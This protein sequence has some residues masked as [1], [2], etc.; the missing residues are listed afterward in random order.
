[1]G[2]PPYYSLSGFNGLELPI[3]KPDKDEF[4]YTIMFWFR[5]HL[6]IQD[7]IHDSYNKHYLFEMEGSVSCF[8]SEGTKL[9]C[10]TTAVDEN[11]APQPYEIQLA[12]LPDIQQW[13]HLTY[14]AHSKEKYSTLRIDFPTEF[15]EV[16]G[17]YA[18]LSGDNAY[19][20]IN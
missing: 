17:G 16:R 7:L 6:S 19:L 20:G 5:S 13:I 1:M 9:K 11:G 10:S 3:S 8:L 12:V 18:S 4:D 15:K 14:T 2:A